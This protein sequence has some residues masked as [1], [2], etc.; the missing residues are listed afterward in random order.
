MAL[1]EEHQLIRDTVA[2]VLADAAS[3]GAVWGQLAELGMLGLL[4]PEDQGGAGLGLAELALIA[5]TLGRNPL[6][7]P[8]LGSE[9]LALPLMAE[10]APGHPALARV[11]SGALVLALADH[12][13]ASPAR[14]ERRGDGW[15]LDGGK[16]LVL[17]AGPAGAFLVTA[18]TGDGPGVFFVPADAAGMQV[19]PYAET[20][21]GPAADLDMR[22]VLLNDVACL[23]CGPAAEQALD[24]ARTRGLLAIAAEMVGGIGELLDL[25]TEY[26]R[27]RKQFGLPLAGFQALQHAATEIYVEL[28]LARSMLDYG[29]RMAEAP[30]M[31]RDLA[32]AAVKL[33]VNAAARVASE[34]AVQ[35][36]GGIGMTM[37]A[38]CGRI[39]ARLAAL[40]L[41]E[42]DEAT[43]RRRLIDSELRLIA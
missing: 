22:G 42:G 13:A 38:K 28:E 1:S 7:L 16:T 39:F 40:R 36:H 20:G 19:L 18:E 5:G 35:L 30:P 4:L 26:L 2:G 15:R 37:E 9:A 17:G 33:R 29:L 21:L 23:A 6:P 14:A 3:A 41:L 10:L 8:W 12:D 43:C 25:T 24:S 27:S 32:L 31:A 11:Q 34:T